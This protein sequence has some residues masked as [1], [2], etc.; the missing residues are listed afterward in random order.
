MWQ[1]YINGLAGLWLVISAYILSG[2]A[3]QT[4]VI[5]TGLVVLVLAIWG[6]VA[7]SSHSHHHEMR[8]SH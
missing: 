8:T 5:V 2:A 6:A 3:V 1:H 4:N 7:H